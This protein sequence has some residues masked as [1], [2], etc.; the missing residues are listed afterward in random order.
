MKKNQ[1]WIFAFLSLMVIIAGGY[2][3]WQQTNSTDTPLIGSGPTEY[4]IIGSDLGLIEFGQ[5][6][7]ELVF[8]INNRLETSTN[9]VYEIVGY[10]SGK[11]FSL[12]HARLLEFRLNDSNFEPALA[13]KWIYSNDGTEVTFHLRHNV[14]FSDGQPLTSEDVAFNLN[15]ISNLGIDEIQPYDG[16]YP[17]NIE[18]EALDEWTIKI[19]SEEALQINKLMLPILPKPFLEKQIERLQYSV[20]SIIQVVEQTIDEQRQT[21]EYFAVDPVEAIDWALKDLEEDVAEK[22]INSVNTLEETLKTNL[23]QLADALAQEEPELKAQVD[24]LIEEVEQLSVYAE[25][26]RWEN[27]DNIKY[28]HLWTI[29]EPLE[30][31]VGAGPFRIKTHIPDDQ[32]V[33]SRNPNYWKT[34]E[35]GVTLPYL[36][37]IRVLSLKENETEV[38]LFESGNVDLTLESVN[39]P[40]SLKNKEEL[41]KNLNGSYPIWITELLWWD[42]PAKRSQP[43]SE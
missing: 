27:S 9:P 21:F 1:L 24:S 32:L 22:P 8:A 26:N 41:E 39:F 15:A 18:A 35:N 33:L 29:Y 31:L 16:L 2:F 38:E 37:Q 11:F 14:K 23:R 5:P 25:T 12:L 42:D 17:K 10:F 7:G 4:K 19:S 30:Q 20:Q 13:S 34:D 43:S 28:E 3:Y 6:G 36:D 40:E